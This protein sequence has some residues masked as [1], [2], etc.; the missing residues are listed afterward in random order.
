MMLN[1]GLALVALK[2]LYD[3][4]RPGLWKHRQI[5]QNKNCLFFLVQPLCTCQAEPLVS[6]SAHKAFDLEL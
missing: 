1:E 3:W 5:P 2:K 6:I 4:H